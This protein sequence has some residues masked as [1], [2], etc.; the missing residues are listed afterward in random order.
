MAVWAALTT[1]K[2]KLDFQMRCSAALQS[3]VGSLWAFQ[4]P[5]PETAAT[6]HRTFPAAPDRQQAKPPLGR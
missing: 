1:G 3:L 6:R 4:R 5:N 2:P